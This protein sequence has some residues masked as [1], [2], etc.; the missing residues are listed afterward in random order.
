VLGYAVVDEVIW[1]QFKARWIDPLQHSDDP[2]RE[3]T[4]QLLL[5]AESEGTERT[6]SATSRLPG[7]SSQNM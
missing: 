4:R 5:V 3:I 6:S 2:I 1:P 7:H